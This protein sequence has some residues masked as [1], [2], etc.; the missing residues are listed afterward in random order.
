MVKLIFYYF[1]C[2]STRVKRDFTIICQMLHSLENNK[3]KKN[4]V[5]LLKRLVSPVMQG[6]CWVWKDFFH[7]CILHQQQLSSLKLVS[8]HRENIY[9]CEII[10]KDIFHTASEVVMNLSLRVCLHDKCLIKLSSVLDLAS[11]YT[12]QACSLVNTTGLVSPG[13]TVLVSLCLK[14]DDVTFQQFSSVSISMF[15]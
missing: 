4:N 6:T 12:Q 8:N 13:C 7:N 5:L 10:R 3:G 14:Q 9:P 2:I 1:T 15:N 11:F